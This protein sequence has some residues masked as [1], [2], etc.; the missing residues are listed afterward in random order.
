MEF[1]D[2][3][4]FAE[5]YFGDDLFFGEEFFLDEELFFEDIEIKEPVIFKGNTN[6]GNELIFDYVGNNESKPA[7]PNYD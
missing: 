3:G 5:E 7:L 2:E 4:F 6:T 1:Y